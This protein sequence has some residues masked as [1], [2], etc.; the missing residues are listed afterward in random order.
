MSL[1]MLFV[2]LSMISYYSTYGHVLRLAEEIQKG[3]ASV[4]GVEA[5]LWQVPETLPKEVLDKMQAP[6]KGEAPIIAPNELAE[7]D[8]YSSDSLQDSG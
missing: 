4:E 6:A 1:Y 7:A 3:A 8:V 2:L 5:K